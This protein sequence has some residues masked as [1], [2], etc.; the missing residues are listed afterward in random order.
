MNKWQKRFDTEEFVFGKE[1]NEFI[2]EAEELFAPGPDILAIAE[3]E[4]RNAV[5]LAGRGNHVTIWDFAESGLV[6]AQQL[7]EENGVELTTELKDLAE[8]EWPEDRY[9]AVICVF[10]HFPSELRKQ[11]LEGVRKT[12]KPGGLFITEVYAK[13]QLT[14]GTGGPKEEDYLY[15]LKD[16]DAFGGWGTLRLEKKEVER[17]EGSGHNGQSCVIQYAGRKK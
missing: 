11:V 14:Y 7:A 5:Y 1:P 2:R 6:K 13:E 10:G 15:S 17:H 16:F 9:D 12:V 8:A 4:G 3:G